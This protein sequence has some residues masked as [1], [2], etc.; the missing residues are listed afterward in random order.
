MTLA[1]GVTDASGA[2]TIDLS[3]PQFPIDGGPNPNAPTHNALI[4]R[5]E[6]PIGVYHL[7]KDFQDALGTLTETIFIGLMATI[8]GLVLAIPFSFLA[9]RNIMFANP[10]T[11]VIYYLVRLVFNIL[12]SIEPLILAVIISIWVGL[13]PF[14]GTLALAVHT[15]ASLGKLYSEAIESIEEGPLEAIRATGANW[16]QVIVYGV[17]PQIVPPFI[18]FTL[19]RWDLNIRSSTILG[20]VG[21]GGI[22]FKLL[23][24]LHQSNYYGAGL[25]VWLIAIV[26]SVI[27][28]T[29]GEVRERFI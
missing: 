23:E 1:H 12:R 10:I 6:H 13:G 28:Y 19:Y 29:S 2:F 8:F 20:A 26:V 4:M 11:R 25:C 16:L 5:Q 15:I 14:A 18:S 17:L 9:A 21:G 24:F 3:I 27:D 7:S 22:G